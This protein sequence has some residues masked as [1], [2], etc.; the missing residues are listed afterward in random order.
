MIQSL[1]DAMDGRVPSPKCSSRRWMKL[2]SSRSL[3][4]RVVILSRISDS[5][6]GPLSRIEASFLGC[7]DGIGEE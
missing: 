6:S 2:S 7:V 5:S 3:V 4:R 1:S